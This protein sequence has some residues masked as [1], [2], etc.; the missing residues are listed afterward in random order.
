MVNERVLL[1]LMVYLYAVR[2]EGVR[3]AVPRALEDMHTWRELAAA[4]TAPERI[5]GEER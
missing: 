2:D 1:P 5:D 3:A 4:T